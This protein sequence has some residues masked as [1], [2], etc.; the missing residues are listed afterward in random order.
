MSATVGAFSASKE[1]SNGFKNDMEKDKLKKENI[2]N[3]S[4]NGDEV[5]E[6]HVK[7]NG[8]DDEEDDSKLIVNK[9]SVDLG[10]QVSLKEQ[11]ERDKV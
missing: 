7:D 5:Q 10:P 9:E 11:L 1:G 6:D 4:C 2:N 3:S 8:G